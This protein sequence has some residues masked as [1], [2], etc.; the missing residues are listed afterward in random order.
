MYIFKFFFLLVIFPVINENHACYMYIFKL[1][2]KNPASSPV[3][4][5]HWACIGVRGR[6]ARGTA[7]PP[8]FGQQ[9]KFGQS[10]FLKTF[11]CFF[12][13]LKRQIFSIL[14]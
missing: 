13:S 7:A 12:I 4:Q 11:L 6:G 2:L 5:D 14:I 1:E 9:E 3:T 8:N 10:H